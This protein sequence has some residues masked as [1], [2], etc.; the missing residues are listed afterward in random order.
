LEEKRK[1]WKKKLERRRR[2]I[3]ELREGP[4][5][6]QRQGEGGTFGKELTGCP[7]VAANLERG[8]CRTQ[9]HKELGKR[10]PPHPA[11]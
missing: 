6:S 3:G 10:L 8:Y 2:H 5:L 4:N 11:P 1:T 7:F 9:R